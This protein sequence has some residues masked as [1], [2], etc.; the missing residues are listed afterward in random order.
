[1]PVIEPLVLLE[2]TVEQTLDQFPVLAAVFVRRGMAC[3]GCAMARFDTLAEV[4]RT[5]GQETEAFLAE[6]DSTARN[7]ADGGRVRAGANGDCHASD[8]HPE[9]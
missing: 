8:R 3:V 9:A 2:R 6:L 5:Y 4:A 1:V 7:A